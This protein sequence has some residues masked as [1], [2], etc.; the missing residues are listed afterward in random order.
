MIQKGTTYAVQY[1]CNSWEQYAE[2]IKHFAPDL[3]QKAIERWG[4]Q[5]SLFPHTDGSYQLIVENKIRNHFLFPEICI[6][7]RKP[8]QAKRTADR[9]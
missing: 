2:Y 3:R 7:R 5:I 1:F 6:F 8:R 9:P 4:D